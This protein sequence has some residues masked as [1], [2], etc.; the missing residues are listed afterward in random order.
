[1]HGIKLSRIIGATI[2]IVAIARA[3]LWKVTSRIVTPGATRIVCNHIRRFM[4]QGQDET[5]SHRNPNQEQQ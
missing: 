3:W 2:V 1:M 5:G 4:A